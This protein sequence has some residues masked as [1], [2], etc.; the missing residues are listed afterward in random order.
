[1]KVVKQPVET[2]SA[3]LIQEEHVNIMKWFFEEKDD[4]KWNFFIDK[5]GKRDTNV[6]KKL[7]SKCNP[8]GSSESDFESAKK[9][10]RKKRTVMWKKF[11]L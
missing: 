1:M 3:E 9:K 8:S 6:L 5:L 7:L 2:K 11:L 10:K 4:E